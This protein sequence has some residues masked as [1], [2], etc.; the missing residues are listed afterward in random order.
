M[1]MSHTDNVQDLRGKGLS[2]R[3]AVLVS[4]KKTKAEAKSDEAPAPSS[5]SREMYPYGL[6]LDLNDDS[7]E[8]LKIESLP[9]VGKTVQVT[10]EARVESVSERDDTRGGKRRSLELQIT[11]MAVK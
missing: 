8:K 7:L 2:E 5:M 9:K 6:R 4:M 10:A 1:A 11:K 3:D